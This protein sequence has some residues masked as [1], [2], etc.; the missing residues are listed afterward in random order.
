MT[1]TN[2][3]DKLTQEERTRQLYLD[4]FAAWTSRDLEGALSYLTEDVI[5]VLNVDGAAVPFAASVEGKPALREKLQLLLDT[6]EFGAI[7]NDSLR[8][9]GLRGSGN[10]KFIYI[11][12]ASGER[13]T[14]RFRFVMERRGDQFCR[15]EEY[16]DAAYL[17]AFVRLIAMPRN[18]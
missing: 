11:H 5:H 17:E 12:F 4:C 2:F 15:I 1:T 10:Y 16:H 6:F 3:L 8:V 14:G 18:N 13:L 9:E 7:V